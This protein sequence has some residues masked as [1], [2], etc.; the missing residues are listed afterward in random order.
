M[1]RLMFDRY[2]PRSDDSRDRSNPWER[3]CGS[4]GGGTE[5]DREEH[6]R[7]VFTR[8]LDVPRGRDREQV[9]DRD[10]VYEID[11]TE[12][13]MLGTIGAFRVVSESD[14][15]DL[16]DDSNNPRRSVRHLEGEGLIRTSPLSSDDRAV[17]LTERG[18]D[19]LE[20]NRYERGDR[21]REPAK[22]SVP[23]SGSHAS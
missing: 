8:G 19:L 18:R 13:R 17:V 14:L 20:A 2:D 1:E 7:D 16:R 11:G 5:R 15:H 12:S 10:R 22:L 23:G 21:S 3:S 9:R 4:R 6:S